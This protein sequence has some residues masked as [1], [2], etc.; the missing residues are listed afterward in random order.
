M[1][2]PF[3]L[4]CRWGTVPTCRQAA[5]SR[6]TGPGRAWSC[7]LALVSGSSSGIAHACSDLGAVLLPAV[8]A[9]KRC[10]PLRAGRDDTILLERCAVP[11]LSAPWHMS[12]LRCGPVNKAMHVCGYYIIPASS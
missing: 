1:S 5:R 12:V 10:A 11:G 6:G 9:R 2:A 3:V 8:T 4:A 7:R